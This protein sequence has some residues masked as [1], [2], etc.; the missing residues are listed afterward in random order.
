M[1]SLLVL[2]YWNLV[3]GR[4]LFRN[5]IPREHIYYIYGRSVELMLHFSNKYA[6]LVGASTSG[7]TTGRVQRYE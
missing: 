1:Y 7:Q 4:R 5:N 3:A 2:I 6:K